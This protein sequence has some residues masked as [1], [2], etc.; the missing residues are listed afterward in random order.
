M[1]AGSGKQH[2][3]SIALN[4]FETCFKFGI[5]L[6]MEWIPRTLNDKADYI[7]RIRDL[8]DW[9]VNPLVFANVNAPWGPHSVDC[10]ANVDNTQLPKFYSRFW[11]PGS[12]AVD[13]FT[14]NWSGDI[15][16]WVPPF[17]LIARTVR[18]AHECKAFG[19]LLVPM[20]TSAYFWPILCPDGCHLAPFVHQCMF[21]QYQPGVFLPGKSGSN[22]GDSLTKD[23][24]ILA[25]WLD[26]TIAPRE[27]TDD[28]CIKQ[29]FGCCESCVC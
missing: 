8:D 9:Q 16:G 25:L 22:I 23:S 18:H 15:N 24:I 14:V 21:L 27:Q 1:Q 3:Q 12:A 5:Y 13:A 11:C 4:I 26:F 20:W 28:F 10:F 19:S 7:S 6:D 17:H 29:F 2:L